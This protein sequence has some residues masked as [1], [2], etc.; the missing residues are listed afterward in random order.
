MFR[1]EVSERQASLLVK[2][3]RE[4]VV[5]TGRDE[6]VDGGRLTMP[7]EGGTVSRDRPGGG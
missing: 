1:N 5:S 2:R 7:S 3:V 4:R 6:E